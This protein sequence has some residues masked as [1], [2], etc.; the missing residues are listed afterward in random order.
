M[1]ALPWSAATSSRLVLLAHASHSKCMDVSTN[2][3]LLLKPAVRVQGPVV[4]LTRVVS[5]CQRMQIGYI[6]F[7]AL[8]V[9]TLSAFKAKL[10]TFVFSRYF[11]PN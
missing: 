6:R 10:K 5:C 11:R 2:N 8:R 9:M 3:T 7:T 1:L 4:G